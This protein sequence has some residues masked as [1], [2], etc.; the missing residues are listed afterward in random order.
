MIGLEIGAGGEGEGV[1]WGLEYKSCRLRVDCDLT[2]ILDHEYEGD[3]APL[4]IS[5][6]L[7]S[8]F[9]CGRGARGHV[10]QCGSDQ[11]GS[12]WIELD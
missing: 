7:E 6:G 10:M 4:V 1:T 2:L 5:P 8:R 12:G 11:I 3:Q 9:W